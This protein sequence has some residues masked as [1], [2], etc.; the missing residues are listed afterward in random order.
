MQIGCLQY[1]LQQEAYAAVDVSLDNYGLDLGL[2]IS[3]LFSFLQLSLLATVGST[4]D[5]F[6]NNQS[7][8]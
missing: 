7:Q 8:T 5:L 1:L 2:I 6:R 3:Y 4:M